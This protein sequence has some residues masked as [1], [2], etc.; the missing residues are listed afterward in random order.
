[1]GTSHKGNTLEIV[2]RLALVGL[3]LA[4]IVTAFVVTT[5]PLARVEVVDFAQEQ[6]SLGSFF[7]LWAD[8]QKALKAAPLAQYIQTVTAGKTEVVTGGTWDSFSTALKET[9]KGNPPDR[10]WKRRIG[11]W[12][13]VYVY[14]R[15]L[16]SPGLVAG[17]PEGEE[18]YAALPDGVWIKAVSMRLTSADFTLG[19]GLHGPPLALVYPLRSLFFPL[20]G[21]AVVV[22][23]LLP[24]P[25]RR[26]GVIAYDRWRIVLGDF[27][28]LLLTSVFISLP[29]LITANALLAVT[30]YWGLTLVFWLIGL[31][32]L[33]AVQVSMS[34]GG[35]QLELL[36][37]RLIRITAWRREE[38]LFADM[39]MVQPA[40]Q[41]PPRWLI[42]A[43]WIAALSGRRGAGAAVLGA[44]SE[45]RGFQ[46]TMK[47]GRVM[48]VWLTDQMG[49]ITMRGS[50]S[51]LLTLSS[52]GV[53]MSTEGVTV[54]GVSI[55]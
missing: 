47:D 48:R 8:E 10:T 14:Q 54:R 16:P 29:F 40:I 34:A 42:I 38:Y 25:R 44:Q 12:N 43:S 18:R 2:R 50:E 13:G 3:V 24:W 22:Y 49:G 39:A 20:L 36:E 31:L 19:A 23:I 51:L 30:E 11:E 52:A 4:A 15:D 53:S 17:L 9:Q 1:M 45:M 26:E 41:L 33:W 5:K 6:Q 7:G 21:L 27:L 55:G 46:I 37:D 28:G 35:L 32:G